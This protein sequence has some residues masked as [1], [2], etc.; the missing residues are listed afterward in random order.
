M[1]DALASFVFDALLALEVGATGQAA[2]NRF[3]LDGVTLG[4]DAHGARAIAIQ[5]L[6]ATSLRLASG[7]LVVEVGRLTLRQLVGQVRI[8]DGKP[9]LHSLQAT[10]AE[11]SDVKVHGP[12]TF[13]REPKEHS[14]AS[15]VQSGPS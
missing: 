12:L 9:R 7:P 15:H 4:L 5:K 10:D 11:L 13:S 6:E 14:P 3:S 2:S 1:A 8:D